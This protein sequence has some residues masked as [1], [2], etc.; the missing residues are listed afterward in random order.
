MST[1]YVVELFAYASLTDDTRGKVVSIFTPEQPLIDLHTHILP[2]VDDGARNDDQALEML[3]AA[4]ADGIQ[5]VAVTPHA[6]HVNAGRILEG[7]ERLRELAGKAGIDIEI[8]PGHEARLAPDLAD[9][10]NRK[11]LLPLNGT[12]YQLIELHL[13]DE[14]PKHLVERS[15]GRIQA[16]G[17]TPIL[18]HPERYPAVRHDPDWVETLIDRGILMQVNSHSLTGY[19]GAEARK[20]AEL[21]LRRKL[22]HLIASDAHNPARRPPVIR[23]ALER[24]AEIAGND[25]VNWMLSSAAAVVRGDEITVPTPALAES[26]GDGG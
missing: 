25:Y 6:H 12:T 15:I 5:I 8:V 18:A 16:V 9:R 22:V 10:Y 21:L 14:W 19:H 7:V 26:S 11:D 17:L 3:R 1:S 24:A 23:A 4:E 20:T 13:F 2:G